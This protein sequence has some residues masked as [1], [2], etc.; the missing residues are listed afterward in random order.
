VCVM[1]IVEGKWVVES[2]SSSSEALLE[3]L[4]DEI[5]KSIGEGKLKLPIKIFD[6]EDIAEAHRFMEFEGGVKVVVLIP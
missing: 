4:L 6:I 1:G 5:A 3:T 2:F